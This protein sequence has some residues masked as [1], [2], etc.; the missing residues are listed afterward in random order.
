MSTPII[1]LTPAVEDTS[2]NNSAAPKMIS[3]IIANAVKSDKPVFSLEF[4][5]PKTQ[6]GLSNLYTRIARMVTDLDP[7]W[8]QIT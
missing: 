3:Q 2:L 1:G 8:I 5:P 7:A 6:Q 4:F